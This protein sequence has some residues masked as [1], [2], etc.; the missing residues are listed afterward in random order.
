MRLAQFALIDAGTSRGRRSLDPPEKSRLAPGSPPHAAGSVPASGSLAGLSCDEFAAV[1]KDALRNFCRADLLGRSPLLR[2]RLLASG[3]TSAELQTLLTRTAD[4]LFTAPRDTKLRRVLELSYFRPAPKQEVAAER[5]GL[6]FSTYRRHLAAA[7]DRL[8][9]WL[10]EREQ[11][12]PSRAPTLSIVVLPFAN[13]SS[14]AGLGYLVDGITENLTTDLSR[15]PDILVIDRNTAFSYQGKVLDPR[16]IGRELGVHYVLEGSIQ[17]EDERIRINAKLV[18]AGSGAQLWADRFDKPREN[19]FDVQD[20]ITA[21]LARSVDIQLVAAESRRVMCKDRDEL[22]SA[23]M[24]LRGRA[25]WNGPLSLEAVREARRLYEA[26]LRL[27]ERN[28]GALIG[29]A[30]THIREVTFYGSE[31]RKEQIRIAEGAAVRALALAPNSA[32]ANFVRGAVLCA[33]GAQQCARQ[34]FDV[35]ITLDGN[36]E[37]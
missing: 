29:L 27:D 32:A 26:A 8:G 18:D 5:L 17:A 15:I 22:N 30:D 35:A 33:T 31:N 6:A 24:R 1:L 2:S 16:D 36:L 14:E 21:R 37:F 11:A 10:W 3:A 7:L 20:E 25:V 13:L 28:V 34:L 9:K 4:E 19:P 23:D 12:A